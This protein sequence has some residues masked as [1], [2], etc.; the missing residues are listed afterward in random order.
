MH[1]GIH[2]TLSDIRVLFHVPVD[3]EQFAM[4]NRIQ[5]LTCESRNVRSTT[6]AAKESPWSSDAPSDIRMCGR[7]LRR[8]SVC[9]PAKAGGREGGNSKLPTQRVAFP[10]QLPGKTGSSTYICFQLKR[11]R[12]RTRCGIFTFHQEAGKCL[13]LGKAIRQ[14][15]AQRNSR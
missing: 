3:V 8:E 6:P 10:T 13:D 4:S 5:I 2:A 15:C 9:A 7:Q 14:L 11:T 1:G 12:V